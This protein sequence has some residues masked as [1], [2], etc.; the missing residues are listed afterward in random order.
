[1]TNRYLIT[2]DEQG[3]ISLPAGAKG[4]IPVANY[5]ENSISNDNIK[6]IHDITGDMDFHGRA[7]FLSVKESHALSRRIADEVAPSI[8]GVTPLINDIVAPFIDAFIDR[9]VRISEVYAVT[10]QWI[11]YPPHYE[12]ALETLFNGKDYKK[13]YKTQQFNWMLMRKTANAVD[14]IVIGRPQL[15][16]SLRNRYRD[17][18]SW[19]SAIDSGGDGIHAAFLS[20]YDSFIRNLGLPIQS[21]PAMCS[22]NPI[23]LDK[24]KRQKIF[25]LAETSLSAIIES[26]DLNVPRQASPN[27]ARLLADIFPHSRLE[28]LRVNTERYEKY[29]DRWKPSLLLTALGHARQDAFLYFLCEAHRRSIPTAILQH[30]GRYGYDPTAPHFFGADLC[31]PDLFLSWGWEI[32]PGNYPINLQR[33]RVVPVPDPKLSKLSQHKWRQPTNLKTLLIPLSKFRTLTFGLGS[34]AHD[35]NLGAIRTSVVKILKNVSADFDRIQVTCRGGQKESDPLW[36]IFQ[37]EKKI[38]WL[39]AKQYPASKAMYEASVVLWDVATTGLFETLAAGVPCVVLLSPK[40]WSKQSRW[41]YDMLI[42]AGI[43]SE[44]DGSA[45]ASVR[46]FLLDPVSWQDARANVEPVCL[47]F[48]RVSADVESIWRKL[49][50]EQSL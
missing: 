43:G 22:S 9:C 45:I 36:K 34:V 15:V 40:N 2:P 44:T 7:T 23:L 3:Y 19:R 20:Q 26:L 17:K 13:A 24:K 1:M 6:T 46:R 25:D 35:G 38:E 10:K 37:Y 8:D 31:L 16:S 49:L 5:V 12:M 47:S 39:D 42:E 27:V 28:C 30:G 21:V 32:P 48:G 11:C 29:F 33:A 14:S 50:T 18:R 41:A 4:V